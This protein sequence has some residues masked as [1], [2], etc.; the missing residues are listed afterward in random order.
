MHWHGCYAKIPKTKLKKG[1]AKRQRVHLV[2]HEILHHMQ[3]RAD[4]KSDL[5]EMKMR[6]KIF[7]DV[8]LP[9]PIV[10]GCKRA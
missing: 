3:S 8:A 7:A 6:V 2:K 9:E 10:C 1:G 5:M 4:A